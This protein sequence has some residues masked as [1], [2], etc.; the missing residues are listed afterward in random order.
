MPELIK[1]RCDSTELNDIKENNLN[2]EYSPNLGNTKVDV[3]MEEICVFWCIDRGN[4][5]ILVY[6]LRKSVYYGVFIRSR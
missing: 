5:C 4:L 3:F 1:V 6:I 2:W